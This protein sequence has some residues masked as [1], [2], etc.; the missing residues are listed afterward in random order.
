[1]NDIQHN[2]ANPA[3]AGTGWADLPVRENPETVTYIPLANWT[4]SLLAN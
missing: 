4:M 2:I 1:M 3:K